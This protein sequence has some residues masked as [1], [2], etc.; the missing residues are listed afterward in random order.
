MHAIQNMWGASGANISLSL[1]L[2]FAKLRH[3]NDTLLVLKMQAVPDTPTQTLWPW[4]ARQSFYSY[5]LWTQIKSWPWTEPRGL[6]LSQKK[7]LIHI[8]RS[9]QITCYNRSQFC[10]F[11]E[12]QSIWQ[13]LLSFLRWWGLCHA[14]QLFKILL[15]SPEFWATEKGHIWQ[16]GIYCLLSAIR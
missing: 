7:L 13:T 16:H 11:E 10:C 6:Y 2:N 1:L 9:K 8:W 14:H 3:L 5:S 15:V 4:Q 12:H